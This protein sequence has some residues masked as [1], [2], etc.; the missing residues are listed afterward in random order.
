MDKMGKLLKLPEQ[1]TEFQAE[2]IKLRQG[3]Y[4]NRL[5]FAA[6]MVLLF[7]GIGFLA[8]FVVSISKGVTEVFSGLQEP[9]N[10]VEA[11]Y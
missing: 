5:K 2:V 10:R 6:F 9:G 7:V 8:G 4:S 1:T 11:P 3:Q